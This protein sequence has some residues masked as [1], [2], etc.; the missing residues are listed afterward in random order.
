MRCTGIMS[1]ILAGTAALGLG[2]ALSGTA[3]AF[4]NSQWTPP[5]SLNN[6]LV[7]WYWGGSADEVM[8]DY[9]GAFVTF[10][11]P[12]VPSSVSANWGGIDN[13]AP[14]L[15]YQQHV[16]PKGWLGWSMFGYGAGINQHMPVSA[17]LIAKMNADGFAPS[18]AGGYNVPGLT[19]GGSGEASSPSSLPPSS[20]T[21]TSS[22]SSTLT[23]SVS[24]APTHSAAPRSSTSSAPTHSTA[25]TSSTQ[26]PPSSSAPVPT[27]SATA[28]P[29]THSVTPTTSKTP[30]SSHS[31]VIP[32]KPIAPP[33]Q[34]RPSYHHYRQALTAEATHLH[35]ASA[36]AP[37]PWPWVGLGVVIVAGGGVGIWQWRRHH[38]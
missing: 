27:H 31:A 5:T 34:A 24:P 11:F 13:P 20:P 9:S 38:G 23:P 7:A 12:T 2:I 14:L 29:V 37:H 19:A 6:P 15:W 35:G 17:S 36:P 26:T 8:F 30:L 10:P 18:M 25:P 32:T 21:P 1:G 33:H 4:T 22:Q 16:S 28:I 3:F